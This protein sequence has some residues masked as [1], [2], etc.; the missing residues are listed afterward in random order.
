MNNSY[1]DKMAI[2]IKEVAEY[3]EYLKHRFGYRKITF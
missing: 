1:D 2:N 3:Y